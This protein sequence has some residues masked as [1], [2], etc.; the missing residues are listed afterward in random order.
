MD[1]LLKDIGPF[2]SKKRAAEISNL[3]DGYIPAVEK[4]HTQLSK[5]GVAFTQTKTENKRLKKKAAEL[6]RSLEA[7]TKTSVLKELRDAQLRRDYE[8]ALTL[9]ERIPK[10]VIEFYQTSK[11]TRKDHENRN[12]SR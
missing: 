12:E 11:Y 5:Y 10:E 6:E 8:D 3:L 4:I 9:L 7:A 2:N 1:E